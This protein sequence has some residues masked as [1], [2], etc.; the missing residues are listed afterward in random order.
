M[1]QNNRI[2]QRCNGKNETDEN[3]GVYEKQ[4]RSK[5]IKFMHYSNHSS[6]K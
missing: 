2:T 1:Y 6:M 4:L 3:V 5:Y